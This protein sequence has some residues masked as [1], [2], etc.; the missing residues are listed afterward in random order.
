MP[1]SRS[2]SSAPRSASRN[3]R[4]RKKIKPSNETDANHGDPPTADA[5]TG[6]V[7]LTVSAML[8]GVESPEAICGGLKLQVASG[9][10]FEHESVTL[11]GKELVVAEMLTLKFA[12][13][14]AGTETPVV[15]F[16]PRLKSKFSLDPV[17]FKVA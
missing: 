17:T 9:G 15:G 16:T 8:C 5:A 12:L 6:A 10:K 4:G 2:E 11:S 1:I 13:L 7:V 14:P 3:F